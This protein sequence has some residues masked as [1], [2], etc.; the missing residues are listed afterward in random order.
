MEFAINNSV[1]ASTGETPVYVNGLRHPWTPVSFVR[2]PSLSEG[3]LLTTIGANA[4]ERNSFAN[5]MAETC[6]SD[7]ASAAVVTTQEWV[8][9]ESLYTLSVLQSNEDRSSLTASTHGRP[10]GGPIGDLDSTSIK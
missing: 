8:K 4:E 7:P 6:S 2:I 5:L 3:G 9:S 10:F 1:H